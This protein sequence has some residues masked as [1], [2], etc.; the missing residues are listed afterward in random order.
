MFRFLLDIPEQQAIT[1]PVLASVSGAEYQVCLQLYKTE[2]PTSKKLI[3]SGG[4]PQ[5]AYGFYS[6]PGNNLRHT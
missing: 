1:T 5:L 6:V 4:M 2:N 3:D